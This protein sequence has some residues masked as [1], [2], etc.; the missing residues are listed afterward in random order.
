MMCF[1]NMLPDGLHGKK[2]ESLLQT[3][4]PLAGATIAFQNLFFKKFKDGS[5]GFAWTILQRLRYYTRGKEEPP[6]SKRI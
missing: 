5:L 3:K 1:Y 4:F 2:A 6:R